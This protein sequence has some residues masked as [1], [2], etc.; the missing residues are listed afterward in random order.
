M[1]TLP[2]PSRYSLAELHSFD[3]K[4]L[5]HTEREDG[6]VV[7]VWESVAD[8]DIKTLK[9]VMASREEQIEDFN[10]Q[11]IVC[12]FSVVNYVEASKVH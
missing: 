12:R 7:P 4:L 6:S 3:G 2:P 1:Y 11:R 10:F 8:E 5:V 9:E